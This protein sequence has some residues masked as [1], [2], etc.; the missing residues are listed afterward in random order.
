MAT[1]PEQGPLAVEV[2][3]AFIQQVRQALEHLYD[4]AYLQRHPL[5]RDN[6]SGAGH[7][8]DMAG[9]ALRSE[10][11]A[12]IE[13]LSPG[14]DVPFR[15]PSA[16]LH[17]L[18]HLQYIEG[19]T[20][21]EAGHEL[22]IST[23]Q[24]F[25]DLKLAVSNVAAIL[26]AHRSAPP[27]ANEASRVCSVQAEVERLEMRP[28]LVD[29]C[30]LLQQAQSAVERLAQLRG[31]RLR[32]EAPE[33]PATISAD[34][35]VAQQVLVSTLSRAVQHA[36]P[37]DLRLSLSAGPDYARLMARYTLEQEDAHPSAD[38]VTARLTERLGWEID[39]RKGDAEYVLTL[40]MAA[41]GPTLLVIDDNQ[42]LVELLERF[43]SGHDC[44]LLAAGSGRE[45]LRLAQQIHPNAIVL[46]V[47]MPAMDGW[48]TLQILRTDPQIS[49]IPVIVCTVFN[50]P[51]LAYSLG[52]SHFLPKPISQDDILGALH[53]L[54]VL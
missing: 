38:H 2:S 53:E 36:H 24:A 9:Q 14:P 22:G 33:G 32:F 11:I 15:A 37:G 21:Q 1:D 35:V 20:V 44:R 19:M 3:D 13:A 45:G 17:N 31:V 39:E 34:P 8:S 18:L 28:Q 5:A 16:R 50:D 10:L 27:T 29:V 40:T 49:S 48:Q 43:L 42:D 4:F 30:V 26:W 54:A 7:T 23:R 12:A 25:R 52:A 46:D 6:G 41:H 47:M 51:E